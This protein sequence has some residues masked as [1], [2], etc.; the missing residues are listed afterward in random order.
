MPFAATCTTPYV[1]SADCVTLNSGTVLV[2]GAG[3]GMI[4]FGA[5]ELPFLELAIANIPID[6]IDVA[7]TSPC[8]SHPP[9][10]PSPIKGEGEENSAVL[11]SP[12]MARSW[13]SHSAHAR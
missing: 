5:V 13:P 9:T 3:S 10:P 12:P 1:G 6:T 2:S 8:V 7:N 4:A 11:S